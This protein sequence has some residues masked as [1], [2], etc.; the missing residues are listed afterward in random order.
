MRTW[1]EIEASFD[2]AAAAA[3]PTYRTRW[4]IG[5]M[6]ESY[7]E[8]PTNVK[9]HTIAGCYEWLSLFWR[10]KV[11]ENELRAEL[12]PSSSASNS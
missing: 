4:A 8:R 6:T 12:A 11:N 5:V 10:G 9:A 7:G 3:D 2:E 1:A